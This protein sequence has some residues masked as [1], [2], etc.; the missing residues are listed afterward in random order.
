MKQLMAPAIP[1]T[2]GFYDEVMR[3]DG[4][5][6]SLGFMKPSPQNPFAYPSSFGMPGFGGSF[7]FAD[8]DAQLAFA[9][10]ANLNGFYLMDPRQTSLRFAMYR[11]I[12]ETDPVL[13]GGRPQRL[14]GR[15]DR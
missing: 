12:G 14:G 11:C 10:V 4:F 13:T 1:P 5:Q 2:R 7:G 9:Y 8:P 3:L 15:R 6:L